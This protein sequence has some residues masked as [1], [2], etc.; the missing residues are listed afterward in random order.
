MCGRFTLF[1]SSAVLS[2]EFSV[3]ITFKLTPRYNVAPSQPVLAVRVSPETKKR[4]ASWFRWGLVPRWAKDDSIG[5]G[6]INARAE[7]VTEK[8]GFRDAFR[9]RRCL[10]P[11]SGFYEWKKEARRK[12]PYYIRRK[13]G[14]PFAFAGLWERWKGKEEAPVESCT[15]VTTEANELVSS[16]H[17]RM[18]MILQPADYKLWLDPEISGRGNILPLLR[19][20]SSQEM[21]AFPVGTIV[22]NPKTEDPRCI[23]SAG[24]SGEEERQR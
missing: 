3:P 21:E 11:A 15:L 20:Y 23:V 17:D 7:T 19:Q 2:T 14:R 9:H 6:M 22:N 16:I 12:Q 24:S 10:V 18:P 8:P 5:Y 13:D 4:D 1:E